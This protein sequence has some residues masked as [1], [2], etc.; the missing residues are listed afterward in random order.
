MYSSV[1][2]AFKLPCTSCV[3]PHP[4]V[5]TN[6]MGFPWATIMSRKKVSDA[7][8]AVGMN[9]VVMDMPGSYF[10]SFTISPQFTNLV[11]SGFT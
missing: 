2:R 5:P 3:F 8:S 10:T 6:M 11:V 9:I 7:V 1:S 4:D